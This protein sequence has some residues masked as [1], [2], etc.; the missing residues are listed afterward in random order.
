[1][2]LECRYFI[3]Q[4]FSTFLISRPPTVHKNI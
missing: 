3:Q 2:Q 1:M 4:W